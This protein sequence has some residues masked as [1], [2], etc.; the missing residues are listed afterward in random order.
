MT[1][2]TWVIIL[3]LVILV[4]AFSNQIIYLLKSAKTTIVSLLTGKDPQ[5]V[6]MEEDDMIM[7][8]DNLY[9]ERLANDPKAN[10][11]TT[12]QPA[13]SDSLMALGYSGG[14]PWDEVIQVSELDPS[15]FINHGEFVKDVRRFSS[16]ANFA[17]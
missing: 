12:Y 2:P 11:V 15:T 13:A 10:S 16:G 14:L 17:S 4:L 3:V 8:E 7:D 6:Q 9:R 5:A 1:I